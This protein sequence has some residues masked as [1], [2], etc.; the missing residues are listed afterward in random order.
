MSDEQITAHGYWGQLQAW[1]ITKCKPGSAGGWLCQDRD[2]QFT[3]IDDPL[4]M[5]PQERMAALS[6]IAKRFGFAD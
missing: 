4:W 5:T 1:G 6:G 3:F 2:G